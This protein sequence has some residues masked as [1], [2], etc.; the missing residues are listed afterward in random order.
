MTT[1]RE[2]RPDEAASVTDAY[3]DACRRHAER[4]DDWGVPRWDD[5]HRWVVRT[6]E[7]DDAVCLVAIT[8]EG[9]IVG[10]L[11]ASVSGH[12]AMPGILGDLEELHVVPGPD[13][14]ALKRA[15]VDAG[16]PGLAAGMRASSAGPSRSRRRGRP[17]SWPSGRR[18]GSRTTPPR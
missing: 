6:T 18:S 14:V 4:D 1:I 7:T 16:S 8:D 10:H 13:E 12:P 3:L 15:L 17:R 2:M 9:S 5:I 11:L